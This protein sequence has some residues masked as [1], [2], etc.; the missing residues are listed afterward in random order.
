M[1]RGLWF[2]GTRPL[3]RI[4]FSSWFF[5]VR[6]IRTTKDKN[7]KERKLLLINGRE[8]NNRRRNNREKNV[9]R[10]KANRL[11]KVRS[12]NNRRVRVFLNNRIRTMICL[13]NNTGLIGSST[14][15]RANIGDG[16][17]R[18]LLSN[19]RRSLS[20][21]LLIT[22]DNFRRKRR[23]LKNISRHRTTTNRR[24][25][26]RDDLNDNRDVLGTRLFL[27][28]LRLNNNA[29]LSS[30]RTTNRLNRALLRLFAIRIK[31]N[32]ISLKAGLHRTDL[33]NIII[34][35]TIRSS[36]ILLNSLRLTNAT[37]RKSKNVLR[38]GTRLLKG[39][40]TA[41]RS[42]SV[43][44]RLLTTITGTKDLSYRTNRDTTRAISSR[45]KR[46]LTLRVLH[47]SSRLFT[48]LRSLL[49]RKGSILGIKGLAINSRRMNVISSNLRLINVNSRVENSVTPI[50]LR[51]LRCLN[52]N[53][54]N[55]KL[56]RNSSTINERLLR[57]LNG[58]LTSSNVT[59]QSNNNKNSILNTTS[60][61]KV[62]L[63]LNGR[64]IR[65]NLGTPLSTRKINT[66]DRVLRTLTSRHLNRRNNNN[67]AI[68]NRIINLSKRFLSRLD[69]RVLGDVIRLSLLN[70]N[71]AIINSRKNTR[72]LVRRRVTTAKTRNGLRNIN[73]LIRAKLR[74]LTNLFT[75]RGRF[76]R[77]GG[78]LGDGM[79]LVRP[80]PRYHPN[81]Q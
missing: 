16:L 49:R 3:S 14:T 6:T 27:F 31:N 9:L 65:N 68:T 71:R 15:F 57:N 43:L 55:L 26:F 74:N 70:S 7:D 2:V 24:T 48:K 56:L 37:R 60:L 80:R 12:A 39:R 52:M 1:V 79:G 11:N 62:I 47:R 28:R 21:N 50:G 23:R 54:N 10:D 22:L 78:L 64:H 25:L 29:N 30:H 44:R 34:T 35:R 69:T 73:R 67:N 13:I 66:N 59:N 58:R 75:M 72:L 36:N 5:L 63:R 42:N 81:K 32:N 77:G 38:L 18:E 40:L 41:N 46:N 61:L 33:S 4:N 19:L 51:A 8:L 20:T 53:V 45:N 76:E 17:T